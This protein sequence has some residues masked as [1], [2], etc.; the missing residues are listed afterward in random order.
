MIMV[1]VVLLLFISTATLPTEAISIEDDRESIK[2]ESEG[3]QPVLIYLRV[4][5]I[6]HWGGIRITMR[7]YDP[8]GDSIIFCWEDGPHGPVHRSGWSG[9]GTWTTTYDYYY[10][11]E[12]T[13]E[14]W[15]VDETDL[16]SNHISVT[17]GIK[18]KQLE[19]RFP[20]KNFDIMGP[21]LKLIFSTLLLR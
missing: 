5:Q 8:D 13:I 12:K 6:D 18:S 14:G 11:G 21:F 4:R 17:I 1:V 20:F 9:G 2:Q 3:N 7:G 16:E 10:G 15:L 19:Q